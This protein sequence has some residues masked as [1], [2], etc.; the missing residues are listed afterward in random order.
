[1]TLD[2]FGDNLDLLSTEAIEAEINNAKKMLINNTD[3]EEPDYNEYHSIQQWAHE[4]DLFQEIE[5]YDEH[6]E[7]LEDYLE[8]RKRQFYPDEDILYIYA[9][10]RLCREDHSETIENVTAE[11]KGID[12]EVIRLNINYCPECKIYFLKQSEYERYREIYKYLPLKMKYMGS[13]GATDFSG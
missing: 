3:P 7:L 2:S 1:M 12:D 11:I 4:M 6:I 8:K 10:F 9:G 5:D 13:S